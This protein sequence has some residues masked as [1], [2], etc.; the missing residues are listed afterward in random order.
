MNGDYNR[1]SAS[2][3]APVRSHF[4]AVISRTV[5]MA[6]VVVGCLTIAPAVYAQSVAGMW[7]AS[8]NTPGGARPFKVDFKQDGE[9]LTGTVKRESGDLP[10]Q[11]TIKGKVVEFSYTV[12]YNGNALTLTVTATVDG[13]AMKGTVSFGGQAEEQFSATRAAQLN[14]ALTKLPPHTE[15][16]QNTEEV[17]TVGSHAH[18]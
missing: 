1:I 3:N 8:M 6:M 14:G 4:S 10:L 11:G 2:S 7:D 17:L 15:G 12:I 5:M 13:N 18:R 9:K 16:R